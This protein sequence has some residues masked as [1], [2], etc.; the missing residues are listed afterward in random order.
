ME[1]EKLVRLIES[2]EKL[3][4]KAEKE[5]ADSVLEVSI[6][7]NVQVIEELM[8]DGR[9]CQALL[10]IMEPHLQ[11][12]E[13]EGLEEGIKEGIKRGINGAIDT[14]RAFGHGDPEI[15]NAIMQRY[16]LSEEEAE[17]Y[18]NGKV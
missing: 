1:K 12:R 8:G 11:R 15:K 10:E 4:G 9:M 3:T 6:G 17:A 5:F 14:L 13:K 16:V 2:T 7:A 18:L